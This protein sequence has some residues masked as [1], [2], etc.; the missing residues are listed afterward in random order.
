MLR[1]RRD[2]T[3]HITSPVRVPRISLPRLERCPTTL[4]GWW[5]SATTLPHANRWM[6]ICPRAPTTRIAIRLSILPPFALPPS[7]YHIPCSGR[8]SQSQH[9]VSPSSS[10]PPSA[11]LPPTYIKSDR[12]HA[13]LQRHHHPQLV[14]SSCSCSHGDSPS[15]SR[16]RRRP[17]SHTT[18]GRSSPSPCARDTT[19]AICIGG[20]RALRCSVVVAIPGIVADHPIACHCPLSPSAVAGPSIVPPA[21]FLDVSPPLRALSASGSRVCSCGL[22]FV[23]GTARPIAHAAIA[24]PL[25][26]VVQ[27]P[28]SYR[29]SY[30]SSRAFLDASTGTV[31]SAAPRRIH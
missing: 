23:R 7:R 21:A 24:I 13:V 16:T 28:S 9:P 27:L 8:P 19:P 12:E 10:S 29:R 17:S 26:V 2:P 4:L 20:D 6:R 30:L 11:H 3:T 25:V 15:R 1:R 31:R 5:S 22:S 18:P 14:C